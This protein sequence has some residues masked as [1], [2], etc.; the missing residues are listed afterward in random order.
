MAKKSKGNVIGFVFLG[1]VLV[2]LVLVIVGMFVG[3]V[4][5]SY[6]KGT[7]TVNESWTLFSDHWNVEKNYVV[8]KLTTPSNSLG[9]VAFI[10]A[11]VGLV[12]LLLTGVIQTLLKK[13]GLMV[14]VLRIAG[15]ALTV[16]GAVLILVSGLTMASEC[17]GE[18][19]EALE[20]AKVFFSAGAGVWLG[21][22]GGL[23]GA[24]CGA[25][26]LLKPFK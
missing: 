9:I 22:I 21:F 25:L 1:L 2:A 20:K 16:V 15:V 4:S 10:L 5:Y 14:T 7:E 13:S 24:V 8:L 19:Q 23:V 3:Q 11:L 6:Q 17:Y 26:P 18:Q 12:V